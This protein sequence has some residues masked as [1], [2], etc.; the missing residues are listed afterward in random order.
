ML[1]NHLYM[2]LQITYQGGADFETFQTE[3][4]IEVLDTINSNYPTMIELGS[5]DCH[6]SILFSNKFNHQCKNICVE[7]SNDLLNLGKENSNKYGCNFIFKHAYIGTVDMKYIE[8][9]PDV[10]TN[11]STHKT[12]LNEIITENNINII[13]ILHMDIQGSEKFVVDELKHL[14]IKVKYL[15]VSTHINS[16]FGNTHEYVEN[17]LLEMGYNITYSDEYNGGYGDGLIIC[18]KL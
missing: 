12:T 11:L 16:L 5:N 17:K 15:F 14:D 4:F 18:T 13:D 7:I 1:N 6:F 10:F 9:H 8:E 2:N 3:K